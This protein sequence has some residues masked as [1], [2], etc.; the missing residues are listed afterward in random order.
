MYVYVCMY[1]ER[2]K[3]PLSTPI[4]AEFGTRYH[5]TNVVSRMNKHMA[6]QSKIEKPRD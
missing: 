1:G 3:T 5:I 2:E 6:I 4:I